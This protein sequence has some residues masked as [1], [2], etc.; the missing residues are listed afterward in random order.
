MRTTKIVGLAA[1][2]FALALPCCARLQAQTRPQPNAPVHRVYVF[3]DSYS[4]SGR[5]YVDGNGPTAVWYAAQKLGI[6]LRTSNKSFGA[7]DSLNFAVSGAPTGS[8]PGRTVDKDALLG[9][10]MQNQ[11]AEFVDLVH[12]GKVRFD[13]GETLF[14][15]AGGLNDGQGMTADTV[16][17]LEDEMRSLYAV[18]ARRF[19][20]AVLPEQVPAFRR[21]ALR[22]NP[23]LWMVPAEMQ[24]ELKDASVQSSDWGLYFDAVMRSPASYGITDTKNSCAG[25]AIFHED[26]TPCADPDAR[27]Y[28]H[29]GHPSTAVHKAAGLMLAEE[30][31]G[32]RVAA[33]APLHLPLWAQHVPLQQGS[34]EADTPGIEV[35]TPATNTTHTAVLICPGGGYQGLA[36]DYEG[37]QVAR[38]L[39]G[40]GVTGIV[41]RYRVAPYAYPVPMLD[42]ERA[43]RL[44]RAHAAEWGFSADH[45]G[46]WGFSAGGHLS[47]FLLTHFNEPL[48]AVAGYTPDATDAVSA[49][50]TFGVLAYP[51]I[52]MQ[53]GLKHPGSEKNLLGDPPDPALV[54]SLSNEL[55]V[56]PDSPPVFLFSTTDDGLVPVLNTVRF[57]EAYVEKHVPAELHLFEHGPHGLGLSGTKPGTSAWPQLVE[58]WMQRNGWMAPE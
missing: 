23:A 46:I 1:A 3:G 24:R 51:V 30:W 55:Q 13:A 35:Y 7:Q 57:Y 36:I 49:K 48:P 17:N 16:K 26:A 10:G 39:A 29:A 11:V 44:A 56:K 25:R 52:S 20:I 28:F 42:A 12:A 6:T 5:G 40:R 34:N 9:L 58:S 27:F 19:R 47:S 43:M 2:V 38:W 4:D 33:V 14:F 21:T 45:V 15:L 22:L 31:Q 18:G 53:P 41:L 37:E 32:K 50:P 54:Q 8:A